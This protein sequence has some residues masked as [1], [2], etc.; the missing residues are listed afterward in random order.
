MHTRVD[1]TGKTYEYI[2]HNA[3]FKVLDN[4]IRNILN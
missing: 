3:D 2:R 4:N 1:G